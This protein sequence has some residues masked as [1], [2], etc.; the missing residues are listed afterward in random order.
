M[1]VEVRLGDFVRVRTWQNYICYGMG[2]IFNKFN[3]IVQEF[4]GFFK[5]EMN[6]TFKRHEF[7][8]FF[9]DI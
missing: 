4:S 9:C 1:I 3:I 2:A 5:P 8:E 7:L 6:C